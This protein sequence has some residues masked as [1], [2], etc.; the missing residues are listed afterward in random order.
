MHEFFTQM[1]T[2]CVENEYEILGNNW[3]AI[4]KDDTEKRFSLHENNKLKGYARQLWIKA[5]DF[6]SANNALSIICHSSC[7]QDGIIKNYINA[8]MPD[9]NTNLSNKI[10]Q[11]NIIYDMNLQKASKIASKLSLKNNLQ[12]ALFKYSLSKLIQNVSAYDIIEFGGNTRFRETENKLD[13]VMFNACI[14]HAYSGIEELQ[15]ELRASKEKPARINRIKNQDVVNELILR[16]KEKNIDI[17]NKIMWS[18]IKNK[19]KLTDKY[20]LPE[21]DI[22]KAFDRNEI[23]AKEISIIDA[24]YYSSTLRGKVSTHTIKEESMSVT[25]VDIGNC[26][27]LLRRLILESIGCWRGWGNGYF[28]GP[29]GNPGFG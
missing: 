18:F 17:E 28:F 4:W 23:S 13:H 20:P 7:L 11:N 5:N 16:L 9:Q 26:Q 22:V 27:D 15:L 2:Q 6:Q 12:Y 3:E 24:I 8:N 21:G 29:P 14:H 1:F 19:T 25:R 10:G